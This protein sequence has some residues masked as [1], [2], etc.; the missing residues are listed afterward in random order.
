MATNVHLRVPLLRRGLPPSENTV[1]LISFHVLLSPWNP[2]HPRSAPRRPPIYLRERP[3]VPQPGSGRAGTRTRA[4]S[5]G[6]HAGDHHATPPPVQQER[7][8]SHTCW[9]SGPCRVLQRRHR[10]QVTPSDCPP[11]PGPFAR[12]WA[13][14]QGTRGLKGRMGGSPFPRG[15]LAWLSAAG[16]GW[17]G[18]PPV[19]RRSSRRRVGRGLVPRA[20]SARAAQRR[21]ERDTGPP[22]HCF[23][24]LSGK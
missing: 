10:R 7:S 24:P 22:P 1:R 19:G 6:T 9:V 18:G 5:S 11:P 2:F 12:G 21:H 14:S 17:G 13:A 15:E 8:I 3:K 4:S 20:H 16:L 23:S